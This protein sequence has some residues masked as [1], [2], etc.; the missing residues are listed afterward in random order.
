MFVNGVFSLSRLPF[1]FVVAVDSIVR[2]KFG[3]QKRQVFL[4]MH[5]T[6]EFWQLCDRFISFAIRETV[7]QAEKSSTLQN[8]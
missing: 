4:N 2:F 7:W 6:I 8:G 1:A 5:E 3:R